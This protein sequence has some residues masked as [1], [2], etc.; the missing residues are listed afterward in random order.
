MNSK[1]KE[2]EAIWAALRQPGSEWVTRVLV[3]GYQK[4]I[5]RERGQEK[6]VQP[7]SRK[8]T[9]K[10][11]CRSGKARQWGIRCVVEAVLS[12]F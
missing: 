5:A 4:A 11:K 9:D 10:S 6:R 12:I 8:V 1:R 3:Q 2:S 7:T